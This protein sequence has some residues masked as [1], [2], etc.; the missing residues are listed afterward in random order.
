MNKTNNNLEFYDSNFWI[1]ENPLSKN[2]SVNDYNLVEILNERKNKYNI[3]GTVIFHFK[4]FFLDPRLGNDAVVKLLSSKGVETLDITGAMFMEK[5]YFTSPENFKDGI[6]KRFKKGF[7]IIAFFPKTHKYPFEANFC[8][9]FYEILN[10]YNFPMMINL[11]EIDITGNKNIEWDKLLIIADKFTNMPIIIDGGLSKELMYTN[12]LSL[13]IKNSSN[14]YINTH[15]LFAMNQIEDL[16][17]YVGADRLIFDTYFPYY[18]TYI[19][20]ERLVNSE[21]NNLEIKKIASQ[22]IKKIFSKI[23]IN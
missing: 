16:A 23:N 14:I 11:N 17:E 2:L 13:L 4:S 1:G 21:L 15:N 7:R 10:Y 3:Q 19:S 18:D 8:K 5:E 20:T 9:K 6:V 22:N 12:Y